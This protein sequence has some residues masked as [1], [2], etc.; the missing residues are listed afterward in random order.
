ML[1]STELTEQEALLLR[2]VLKEREIVPNEKLSG[3]ISKIENRLL[4]RD[5][6][7]NLSETELDMVNSIVDSVKSNGKMTI[8]LTGIRYCSCCTKKCDYV[9]RTRSTKY[10]RKGTKNMD[11]P[12]MFRGFHINPGFIVVEG[13][14]KLG[15]CV[16]CEPR[17]FPV[18]MD[19]LKDLKVELPLIKG[20]TT[21]YIKSQGYKCECGW[22]G[23][24]HETKACTTL[25]G[26][27]YYSTCPSCNRDSIFS[28]LKET[29]D[30]V[31]LDRDTFPEKTV[32]GRLTY[33]L[34]GMSREQYNVFMGQ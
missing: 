20:V 32:N 31:M 25:M 19:L 7:N 15:F 8:R 26:N 11:K 5:T 1:E 12:I 28:S 30:F 17:V 22:N 4:L 18:I 13:H 14:I 2:D 27:G 10:Y 34:F 16:D 33:V 23:F 29:D 21:K 6:H 24:K 9:I 3:L